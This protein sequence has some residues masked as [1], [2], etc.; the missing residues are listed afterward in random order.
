[1]VKYGV[2]MPWIAYNNIA[3]APV[4]TGNVD[5]DALLVVITEDGDVAPN[6]W[7]TTTDRVASSE[8]DSRSGVIAISNS[9]GAVTNGK[10]VDTV[11]TLASG[12]SGTFRFKRKIKQ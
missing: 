3:N 1:M 5:L 12:Q 2:W 7:A 4:G 8:S 11:G 9:T 6:N 10:Y